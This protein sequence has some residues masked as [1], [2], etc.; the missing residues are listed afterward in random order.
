MI[1]EITG[2]EIRGGDQRAHEIENKRGGVKERKKGGKKVA[3]A[4]E[5]LARF[6]TVATA[7]NNDDV[8]FHMNFLSKTRYLPA[9]QRT[10]TTALRRSFA[11]S[12]SLRNR[13]SHK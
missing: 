5:G 1:E 8:A 4:E 7:D 3:R 12:R 11:G 9:S 10:C 6:F 2:I 13:R